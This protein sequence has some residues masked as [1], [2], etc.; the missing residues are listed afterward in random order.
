MVE[1]SF[2]PLHTYMPQ[3]PYITV[4]TLMQLMANLDNTKWWKTTETLA[5]GYS[6][7]STQWE[8]PNEYQHDRV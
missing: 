4:L 2:Q 8:L 7:D 3:K 1:N 5:N 6:S